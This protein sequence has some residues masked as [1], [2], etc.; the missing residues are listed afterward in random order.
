MANEYDGLRSFLAQCEPLGEVKVVRDADWNLEIGA[1]TTLPAFAANPSFLAIDPSATHLYAVSENTSQVGAY[2][3]APATG[4]LTFINQAP[5]GGRG[6]AR[7]SLKI[8]CPRC[9]FRIYDYPRVCVGFAVER[10]G[11]LLMLIRG[12]EPKRPKTL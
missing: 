6:P 5:S 7:G 4:A 2:A 12:H 1:L 10:R 11:H 9:R 8:G 3:I